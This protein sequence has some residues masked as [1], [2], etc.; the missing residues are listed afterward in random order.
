MTDENKL[1]ELHFDDE[2]PKTPQLPE[3][4]FDDAPEEEPKKAPAEKAEAN[5][6]TTLEALIRGGGQGVT[7][8]FGDELTA[9]V[10][11]A[12]DSIGSDSVDFG[13]AYQAWKN[14]INKRDAQA[15]KEHKGAY[16]TGEIGGGV[17]N[18]LAL[19]AAGKAIPA[20]SKTAS[21]VNPTLG[22][23]N[24]G[25]TWTDFA[26]AGALM[27]GAMGAGQSQANL[28]SGDSLNTET[29]KLIDDM[30]AGA[31]T[32]AALS[33][34]AVLGGK[35][36][37]KTVQGGAKG[38]AK[39][40]GKGDIADEYMQHAAE[41]NHPDINFE[42]IQ[43]QLDSH[44]QKV[45]QAESDAKA[46]M[47]DF[48]DQLP[49]RRDTIHTAQ[50]DLKAA[51]DAHAAKVE[52]FKQFEKESNKTVRDV[53]DGFDKMHKGWTQ[54]VAA[55]EEAL[56]NTDK[57]NA[58][59]V[60][61]AQ[62]AVEA[63][64]DAAEKKL[65]SELKG[66]LPS[67][68]A[69]TAVTG[70]L[71][72]LE[73]QIKEAAAK[74][75][76]TLPVGTK[77]SMKPLYDELGQ[78]IEARKIAGEL[79]AG[80]TPGRYLEWLQN[81]LVRTAEDGD[82]TISEVVDL[83][84]AEIVRLRQNTKGGG[85]NLPN[86]EPVRGADAHAR[87]FRQRLNDILESL[88]PGDEHKASRKA[89]HE[90]LNVSDDAAPIFGKQEP[91]A[92][93]SELARVADPKHADKRAILTKLGKTTGVDVEGPLAPYLEAQKALKDP[94]AFAAMLQKSNPTEAEQAALDSLIARADG[95][96]AAAKKAIEATK[97]EVG[98]KVTSEE[99]GA[100]AAWWHK[101][102]QQEDE[103]QKVAQS[104]KE[105]AEAEASFNER[106]G[107]RSKY[108]VERDLQAQSRA[109]RKEF[110]AARDASRAVSS[111]VKR[112]PTQG[113]QDAIRR[114]IFS[115]PNKPETLLKQELAKLGTE[116]GDPDLARKL[117]M[118]RIK[119]RLM[120]GGPNGSRVANMF[121]NIGA[122]VGD[123]SKLPLARTGGKALGSIL[124]GLADYSTGTIT[125]KALD[126]AI[127]ARSVP[128]LQGLTPAAVDSMNDKYRQVLDQ[129]AAQG[130]DKLGLTHQLLL[131]TDPEYR[132]A[133]DAAKKPEG[134]E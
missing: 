69:Q 122:W 112:D 42:K 9:M 59:A 35:A 30:L 63:A 94:E 44:G 84:P 79:D 12:K 61:E 132:K 2:E 78:Q 130:P 114:A 96:S 7:L 25:K 129:A 134:A 56:A 36:L 45:F 111:I 11:A 102:L 128:L 37:E 105:L 71:A 39:I 64:R 110:E 66:V 70:A 51:R 8:G 120:T 22:A 58:A 57:T 97:K 16:R 41:V 100:D 28:I 95:E 1:P 31:A 53:Y 126:A 119:Q 14:V 104:A 83:S 109:L 81:R 90:L 20:L 99:Q 115:N 67:D 55:A 88:T 19:G 77:T 108:E 127:S 98:E 123:K 133:M 15:E 72:K 62:K 86:G 74:Q 3:L 46:A 47:Q 93:R 60:K 43:E 91:D 6:T 107:G 118:L 82:N 18:G 54:D 92:L 124:G 38:I 17:L 32:G 75:T 131:R 65:R 5:P 101:L 68:E 33:P 10:G 113:S 48:T 23:L 52:A 87:A 125:K 13:Q 26:K 4:K 121:G 85:F 103:A 21:A 116:M 80:D 24:K 76:A 106:M 89:L 117:D 27:G 40:F 73:G 34:V 49:V 29:S 50:A